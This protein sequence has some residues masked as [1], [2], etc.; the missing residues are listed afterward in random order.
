MES[1]KN[2]NCQ[3]KQEKKKKNIGGIMQPD[4]I[5]FGHISLGNG[6]KSKNK[7]VGLY[8]TKKL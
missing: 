1:Q 3:N 2:S 4:F 6:N 8:Q 5:F 7:Q